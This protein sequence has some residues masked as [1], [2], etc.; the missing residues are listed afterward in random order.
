MFFRSESKMTR[1]AEKGTQREPSVRE[2]LTDPVVQAVMQA[3]AVSVEDLLAMLGRVQSGDHFG[4]DRS[5]RGL[6][7]TGAS[8]G[9]ASDIS[10][11]PSPETAN[12]IQIKVETISQLFHTLDPYP[13][14]EKDLDDEAEAFIVGWARELPAD[15]PI[16]IVVHL[17]ASECDTPAGR[18]LSFAIKQYFDNRARVIGLDLK[19]FFRLGR[20]SLGI[21]L[22]VLSVCTVA[23]QIISHLAPYPL[24][25]IIQESFLI[26]GWVANWEPIEIF[27]YGWWPILRRRNLYRRLSEAHVDLRHDGRQKA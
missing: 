19:E 12:S 15:E 3:D 13:F 14:R 9:P 4:S 20:R 21:G 27:L 18:D 17:P 2:L 5:L 10:V 25:R 16:N 26:L 24:S 1:C 7:R 11:A 23:S 6:C 8:S 22:V